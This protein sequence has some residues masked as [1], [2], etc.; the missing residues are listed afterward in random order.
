VNRQQMA[1]RAVEVEQLIAEDD[2][3]RAIWQLVGKLDLSSF[4]KSI[5][6]VEGEAGRP[7]LI[8][9]YGVQINFASDVGC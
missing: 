9:R 3:A 4:Y 7:A 8:L 6:A 2:P 5:G 1:W